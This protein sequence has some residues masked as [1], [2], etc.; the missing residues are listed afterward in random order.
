MSLHVDMACTLSKLGID[1]P[2][3]ATAWATFQED[4]GQGVEETEE[5]RE[6]RLVHPQDV[7]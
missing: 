5:E 3:D 4:K 6:A 2:E 7:E 1:G